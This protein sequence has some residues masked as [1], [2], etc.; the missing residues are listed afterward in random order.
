LHPGHA[1]VLVVEQ[2]GYPSVPPRLGGHL[3]LEPAPSILPWIATE[4]KPR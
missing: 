3:V 2:I 4:P 1:V